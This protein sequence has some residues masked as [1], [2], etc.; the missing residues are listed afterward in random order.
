MC[1]AMRGVQDVHSSTVTSE[2]TGK[3][4]DCNTREELMNYIMLGIK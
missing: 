4:L 3:F 2:F 1:V